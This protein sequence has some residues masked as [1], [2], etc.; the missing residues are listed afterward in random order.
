MIVA[1]APDAVRTKP[2]LGSTVY[3][4]PRSAWICVPSAALSYTIVTVNETSAPI[5]TGTPDHV[6]V[7][8]DAMQSSPRAGSLLAPADPVDPPYVTVPLPAPPG[9]LTMKDRS[10]S[11]AAPPKFFTLNEYTVVPETTPSSGTPVGVFVYP[12]DVSLRLGLASRNGSRIST[13]GFSNVRSTVTM[14]GSL[15]YPAGAMSSRTVY[16]PSTSPDMENSPGAGSSSNVP[17]AMP[18]TSSTTEK[19]TSGVSTI[20]SGSVDESRVSVR[21]TANVAP[22]KGRPALSTLCQMIAPAMKIFVAS[23]ELPWVLSVSPKLD[24][25]VTVQVPPDVPTEAHVS[26]EIVLSAPPTSDR[27]TVTGVP[28]GTAWGPTPPP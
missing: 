7:Q 6:T 28:S 8:P 2:S 10:S 9:T 24:V 19:H 11:A 27:V 16:S 1:G 13:V 21:Q 26:L 14:S 3:V 15:A 25:N 5:P 17:P 23:P 22:P 18:S 4:A 20:V 12:N